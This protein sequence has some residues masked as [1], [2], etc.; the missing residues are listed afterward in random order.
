MVLLM[1]MQLIHELLQE[2]ITNVYRYESVLLRARAAL[3]GAGVVALTAAG[4]A[5]TKSGILTPMVSGV[6]DSMPGIP[7]VSD[8]IEPPDP[9]DKEFAVDPSRTDWNYERATA[10]RRFISPLMMVLQLIP[11]TF[12]SILDTYGAKA[13]FFCGQTNSPIICRLLQKSMNAAIP[14]VS[15]R[16]RTTIRI[17]TSEET[18]F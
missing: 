17:Y 11:K 10:K 9:R 14:W 6:A 7:D 2:P 13:T 8:V 18:Y 3:A 1:A 16:I 15:T 4:I 5:V 12:I